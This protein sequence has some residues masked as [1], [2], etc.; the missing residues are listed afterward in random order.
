M[1]TETITYKIFKFDEL[2]DEA[3]EKALETCRDYNVDGD[4]WH[5]Y[6]T[7]DFA[8]TTTKFDVDKVYFSGFWSQGDGAMFEYSGISQ[9]L[10][11]EAIDSLTLPNWKKNAMKM[12]SSF[13]ANGKHSGHYHHENSCQH[14]LSFEGDNSDHENICDLFD[15]YHDDLE[16]FIIEE[17]KDIARELYRT[18][19]KD[20]EHRTSDEAVQETIEANEYEF[21]EDGTRY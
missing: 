19:E 5:D 18:L 17:Y 7:E 6:T 16:E 11:N 15:L 9:E 2:S 12:E 14:N 1:R 8:E 21:N 20:Y 3:K 13:S 4:F 10:I